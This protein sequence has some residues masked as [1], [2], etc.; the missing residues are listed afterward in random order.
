MIA[1]MQN[2][3]EWRARG[4]VSRILLFI[5]PQ[6]QVLD[7]GWG[8]GHNGQRLRQVRQA[9]VSGLDVVDISVAGPRPRLYDGRHIPF[10]D[11]TFDVSVLIYT[12]HYIDDPTSFLKEVMRVTKRRVLI[13]QTTC[14]GA[15]GRRLHRVN[16][17][18]FGNAAFHIARACGLVGPVPCSMLS[19]HDFSLKDL[20]G[21]GHQAG[22]TLEYARLES[23]GGFLPIGRS[24]C[25]FAKSGNGH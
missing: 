22:L 25:A 2:I 4:L 9:D 17:W 8:T 3:L 20:L 10:P 5:Q 24:T 15:A 1:L 18:L 19:K 21:Y 7:I 23:Y 13:V 12:L 14:R 11:E 16:E 6:E